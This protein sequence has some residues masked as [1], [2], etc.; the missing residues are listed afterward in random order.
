MEDRLKQAKAENERLIK[1]KQ[2]E[3]ANAKRS[4]P[5]DPG[6]AERAGAAMSALEKANEKLFIANKT[7]EDFN[8]LKIA[9][10]P[11]FI[12]EM[13]AFNLMK[14]GFVAFTGT[15]GAATAFGASL[16]Q[17]ALAGL[18]TVGGLRGMASPRTQRVIA[19]QTGAQQAI[20]RGINS[21][22]GQMV[23][24]IL[25]SNLPIVTAGMLTGE[26]Q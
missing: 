12:Q 26:Q 9:E 16:P 8:N 23:K 7:L 15:S 22:G 25:G 20:Q 3:L 2:K 21:Q 18:A 4:M 10:M 6:S 13:A 5:W 17:A 11:S 19:G 24:Q 1:Q 14:S